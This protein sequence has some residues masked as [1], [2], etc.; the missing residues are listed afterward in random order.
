MSQYFFKLE[1]DADEAGP[2]SAGQLRQ[3]FEKGVL[4]GVTAVRELDGRE[5][6]PIA[7]VLTPPEDDVVPRKLILNRVKTPIPLAIPGGTKGKAREKETAESGEKSVDLL[8]ILSAAEGKTEAT[9][10]TQKVRQRQEKVAAALLPGLGALLL[11]S[12]LSFLWVEKEAVFRAWQTGEYLSLGGHV[13]I[14]LGVFDI[15]LALGVL[16][17]SEFAFRWARA[18][19]G[20]GVGLFIVINYSVADFLVAWCWA[21]VSFLLLV[22]M[23][24]KYRW[25]LVLA[26]LAGVVLS[27]WAAFLLQSSGQDFLFH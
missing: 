16:L 13:L 26:V 22:A 11:V 1:G 14:V 23:G 27:L 20:A 19:G 8:G 21:G 24:A 4:Q 6:I 12:G 10:H 3:L 7:E 18:R 25:L 9:A 5:S 2:F 17:G 15:L